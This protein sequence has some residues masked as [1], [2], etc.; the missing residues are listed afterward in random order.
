MARGRKKKI[1]IDAVPDA[2]SDEPI[3]VSTVKAYT[4]VSPSEC[5]AREMLSETN[6]GKS[7]AIEVLIM[8]AHGKG[9]QCRPALAPHLSFDLRALSM[10]DAA[11]QALHGPL[12]RAIECLS[13]DCP[14]VRILLP[15][16]FRG[17]CSFGVLL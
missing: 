2:I 4:C 10:S 7:D 17:G 8:K 11:W 5:G 13:P 14:D 16:S 1:R 9:A 15:E 6:R 12:R 3:A